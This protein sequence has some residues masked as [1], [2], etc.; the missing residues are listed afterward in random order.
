M[1]MASHCVRLTLPGMMDEPGSF[2]RDGDLAQP[3]ARPAGQPSAHIVGNLHQ[4]DRQPLERAV[5]LHR[6]IAAGRGFKL[7][8]CRHQCSAGQVSQFF[9]TAWA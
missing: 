7:V 3:A 5:G 4:T 8:R 6:G 2:F 9:G 1:V